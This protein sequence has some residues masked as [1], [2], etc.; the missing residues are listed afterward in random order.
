MG[1]RSAKYEYW[2]SPNGEWHWHLKGLNGEIQSSGEGY[3]RKG[4][5][6]A[7]IKAHRRSAA[8]ERVVEIHPHN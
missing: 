2:Q 6:L 8:T 4:G 5:A 1:Q 3:K 7:G